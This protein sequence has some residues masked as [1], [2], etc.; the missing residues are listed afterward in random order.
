MPEILEHSLLGPTIYRI[1]VVA[2]EVAARRRAG[3]FVILKIDEKGER[4]PL[5]ICDADPDRGTLTLIFQAVG[6]STQY[7]ASMKVGDIIQDIAGPLG[8]PTEVK[9][10]GTVVCIGGGIGIAPVYPIAKAMKSAGN[11]VISI[12]GARSKDLLILEDEMRKASDELKICTDDGSY[13]RQGFTSDI[14]KELITQSVRIDLV[15]A[16]GPVPM[17]K[18]IADV[19]RGPNIKTIVSLNPIMVDGTGMCGCC[20]V[21]V[22]SKTKFA[23][24]DGPEFDA[25]LVDFSEL[26]QR[27]RIYCPQEKDAVER[28][29]NASTTCQ[30]KK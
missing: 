19:T 21:S 17:M 8:H 13:I 11:R 16:I 7:L 27:L 24:V 18:V 30:C 28:F 25:H 14:L 6:K 12:I 5:T 10:Y 23:C 4:I 20:R 29:H 1:V 26:M 15:V 3:Q 22:G 2:P 9:Q